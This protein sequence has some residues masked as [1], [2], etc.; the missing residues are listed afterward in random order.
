MKPTSELK[1]IADLLGGKFAIL[2]GAGISFDSGLPLGMPLAERVLD[3]L[4]IKEREKV[5]LKYA[6]N[7]DYITNLGWHNY[8][9]A[10]EKTWHM[11][12][13]LLE[14]DEEIYDGWENFSYQSAAS[15]F[16]YFT[17]IGASIPLILF[18]LHLPDPND[19]FG[20]DAWR[21]IE[22][23]EKTSFETINSFREP[24]PRELESFKKEL[25]PEILE[26]AKRLLKSFGESS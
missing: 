11:A 7:P 5:E 24:D 13:S 18:S 4:Y 3:Y 1:I 21:N 17:K 26:M 15:L 10:D 9:Q 20:E 25:K 6:L 16:Q 8:I 23:F 2:A 14:W 19:D 22:N 12:I